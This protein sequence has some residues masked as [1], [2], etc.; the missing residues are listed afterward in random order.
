MS[1]LIRAELLKLRT[2]RL[3]FVFALAISGLALL[4]TIATALTA[5]RADAG[6]PP[7]ETP[8]GV[9]NVFSSG[10]G[11]ATVWAMVLGVI[12]ASG[13]W[14]HRTVTQT[15]LLTPRRH[16][17]VTAKLV[18]MLAVGTLYAVLTVAVTVVSALVTLRI[19]GV[20]AGVTEHGV[21]RALL[22]GAL[23]T[24]IY[25]IVGVGV[26]ALVRNQVAAII[27][28]LIWDG[29]ANTLLVQFL[30]ALGRWTPTGASSAMT[31]VSSTDTDLL[32]MWAGALVLTAYAVV[33]A[34]AGTAMIE[35]RD[36]T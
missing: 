6:T 33:L 7:L 25:G 24:V 23:A 30:P 35:R 29:V 12:V 20:D 15:F 16:R 32:P 1:A 13:E 5:G 11:A 18:A 10:V 17:V 34:A 3:P 4:G 2:T 28:S 36:V 31:G 9:R 21:P 26:G 19:K 22:G 8:E 27:G 14:R